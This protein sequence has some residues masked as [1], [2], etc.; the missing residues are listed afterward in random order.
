MVLRDRAVI[1]MERDGVVGEFHLPGAEETN[2]LDRQMLI[3]NRGQV[4]SEIL[5]VIPLLP[6]G[7]ADAEGINIDAGQGQDTIRLEFDNG[8]ERDYDP[9]LQWGDGST[10]TSPNDAT[11]AHPQTKKQVLQHWARKS[12]TDSLNPARLHI[13]EWT[14]GRFGAPGIFGEPIECIIINVN[15]S[16]ENDNPSHFDGTVELMRTSSFPDIPTDVDIARVD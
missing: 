8:N 5:D 7:G 16:W 3:G 2:D 9:P 14:D 4:I 15:T 12:R 1:V 6:G 13:G 11:G 10:G